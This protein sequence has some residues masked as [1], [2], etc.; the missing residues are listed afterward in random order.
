MYFLG[1]IMNPLN[2]ASL[3]ING[4]TP[5]RKGGWPI[6]PVYEAET[7]EV[8]QQVLKS[9]RWAISSVYNGNP[10]YE[11][12][13][14]KAFAEFCGVNYCIPTD[15]GSSAL[16]IAL[17]ALDIGYGDEV[18][19][20]ALTWVAT[21]SAVT[22]VNAL[23]VIVDVDPDTLCI[24]PGQIEVAITSRTKAIIPVHLYSGMANMDA[25][26]AISKKYNIPIIEDSSH[27]HGAQW[28]NKCAGAIGTLGT[29]SMQH[30]KV[31]TCGEGGTVITDDPILAK[32][33]EQ[34][35]SD[36]RIYLNRDF[37]TYDMELE[38]LGEV[39]G[40]NFCLSEFHA[41]VLVDQLTRLES[42]NRTRENNSYYLDHLLG[43]MEGVIPLK[44]Y[45]GLT[46]RTIYCYVVKIKKEF[47]VNTSIHDWCQ[48][49]SAELA[50]PFNPVYEPVHQVLSYNPMSKKRF[51]SLIDHQSDFQKSRFPCPNGEAAYRQCIAFPHWVLLGSR[52]DM[53][54]IAEA[55]NKLFK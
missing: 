22:N 43:K 23:P 38:T 42:Q 28:K 31:L 6:W 52:K 9:R 46:R 13:F 44:L 19:V 3:A 53:E 12:K 30:S 24:D 10:L 51:R 34:L 29:F 39:Q 37:K 45:P 40:T 27:V 49:L 7:V 50:I 2:S 41:A 26:L 55:F 21:A 1:A 16:L 14:A 36:S 47:L 11:K 33:L 5:I 8:L 17:E 20:P 25:L 35:R 32:K 48:A 18:I 54:D 4:G 15:H